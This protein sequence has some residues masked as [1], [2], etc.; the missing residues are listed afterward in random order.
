MKHPFL[1]VDVAVVLSMGGFVCNDLP[2]WCV[3]ALGWPLWLEAVHPLNFCLECMPPP[4]DVS[5]ESEQGLFPVLKASQTFLPKPTQTSLMML[6]RGSF[7]YQHP[8]EAVRLC[9]A[10]VA[11]VTGIL[12]I[13]VI[14]WLPFWLCLLN[15]WKVLTFHL[16]HILINVLPVEWKK[17]FYY[18]HL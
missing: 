18:E 5:P 2:V 14:V 10:A 12:A 3:G 4:P 13:F 7:A 17:L 11:R 9:C 8:A 15:K 16:A 6:T 1:E